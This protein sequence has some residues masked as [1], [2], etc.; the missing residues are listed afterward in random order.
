VHGASLPPLPLL[1]SLPSPTKTQRPDLIAS[2]TQTK[3]PPR[4]LCELARS[5]CEKRQSLPTPP[6]RTAKPGEESV[7]AFLAWA[8]QLPM[9]KDELFDPEDV[10]TVTDH[11]Q[12]LDS[13]LLLKVRMEASNSSAPQTVYKAIKGDVI[14]TR[15]AA[16]MVELGIDPNVLQLRRTAEG[17]Y[18]LGPDGKVV[19]MRLVGNK[20]MVR[21]GGGYQELKEYLK[22]KYFAHSQSDSRV[23]WS[24]SNAAKHG[25]AG[26]DA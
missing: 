10:L 1:L 16:T 15:I 9:A 3:P 20:V 4:Y 14:D 8:Q 26:P 7:N 13:L 6:A 2:P 21:I 11:D 23:Q 25:L 18:T 5:L 22:E 19:N 12:V 24:K 17:R